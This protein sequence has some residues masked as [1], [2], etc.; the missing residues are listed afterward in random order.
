[1]AL[2]HG[3]VHWWLDVQF[4]Q[5]SVQCASSLQDELAAVTDVNGCCHECNLTPSI[6]ELPDGQ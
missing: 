2:L 3:Q 1:M 6:T 5:S 4:P